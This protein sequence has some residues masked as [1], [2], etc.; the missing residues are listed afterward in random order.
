MEEIQKVD[1][2]VVNGVDIPLGGQGG[3]SGKILHKWKIGA[4]GQSVDYSEDENNFADVIEDKANFINHDIVLD[5]SPAGMSGAY[6][7][8]MGFCMEQ[9]GQ[10]VINA[11]LAL[12]APMNVI[13]NTDGTVA[14][15]ELDF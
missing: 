9:D 12:Q 7:A 13:L 11:Y 14:Q 8:T 4:D 2:I 3:G 1:T 6:C 10:I 15:I 5:L